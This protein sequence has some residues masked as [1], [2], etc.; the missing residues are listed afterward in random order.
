MT[1]IEE[2]RNKVKGMGKKEFTFQKMVEYGFWPKD[3]PTPYERQANETPEDYKKRKKLLEEYNK[4]SSQ[5]TDLYTEISAIDKKL[6]EFREKYKNIQDYEK[7]RR[8]VSRTI[9]EE[10]IQRRAERKAQR[11]AEKEA[12]SKAWQKKKAETIVYIGRGYSNYLQMI[13]TDNEK[14]EKAGLPVITDDKQLAEFLELSYTEL[15]FL[16]YHRDVV[17]K[18][19]YYRYEIPKKSGGTRKIAA[20]KSGLKKAQRKILTGILEKIPVAATA[21]GF[22]KGRSIVTGATAHKLA[23]AL[24]IN[25]DL[26]NFFPTITFERVRGVFQKLGYSGYIASILAM[27]CT[28]CERIPLEV[29]G[30]T[31][32]VK[33]SDRILP[34]G[35]PASPML[36]NIICRNL[37]ARLSGLAVKYGYQYTRYADDMSFTLDGE[38]EAKLG[39][40]LNY[41]EKIIKEEGFQI[42]QK[43]TRILRPNTCQ[44]VTGIV[45]NGEQPGV[46]KKWV[47]NFRALLHHA[48]LEAEKGEIPKAMQYQ[49]S[50]RVA[51]L[52]EVNPERYQ[53]LIEKAQKLLN[54]E[55]ETL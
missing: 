4:L 31:C 17:K 14:L 16:A 29:K 49:I 18:D 34:Q 21:H 32:Y 26:E 55:D 37:D 12:R 30:E 19:Q 6:F 15:R 50:G 53:A 48:K 13:E 27:L 54:K 45:L 9:M 39:Q 33:V 36:T 51:W 38:K 46:S 3:L 40:F 44:S 47:K 5:I 52:K 20:P 2:Y 43:K 24:L 35:S 25:M 11:E 10:S 42:N 41:A 28:Y 1:I 22:L 8:E 23:P 7:I